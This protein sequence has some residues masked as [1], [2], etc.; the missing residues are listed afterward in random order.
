VCS[1]DLNIGHT[2]VARALA[3]GLQAA[4]REM[5]ALIQNPRRDPLFGS[6]V[7]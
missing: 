3:V 6:R 4:V 1:S 5:R 2:I 7:P